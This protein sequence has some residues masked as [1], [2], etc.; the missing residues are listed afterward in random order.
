MYSIELHYDSGAVIGYPAGT[1]PLF[2][3][4]KMARAFKLYRL[5]I[6]DDGNHSPLIDIT[7]YFILFQR[8]WRARRAFFR[9]IL[10]RILLR[11]RAG[12]RL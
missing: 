9:G 5:D 3:R 12:F 1:S 11:E 6:Y 7:R 8:R 4:L 10:R 2:L